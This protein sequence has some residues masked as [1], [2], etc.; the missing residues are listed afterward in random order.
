MQSKYG[1]KEQCKNFDDPIIVEE[2]RITNEIYQLVIKDKSLFMVQLSDK[3]GTSG[4]KG[5]KDLVQ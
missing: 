1:W 3:V 4:T 2:V 5:A